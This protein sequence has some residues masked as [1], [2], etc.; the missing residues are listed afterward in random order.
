MIYEVLSLR[1]A[2]ILCIL[3]LTDVERVDSPQR[4]YTNRVRLRVNLLFLLVI[5]IE[6]VHNE[7]RCD[8]RKMCSG[9]DCSA[10]LRKWGGMWPEV[11]VKGQ[12]THC[13][14]ASL[15]QVNFYYNRIKAHLLTA[16]VIQDHKR[17]PSSAQWTLKG[18]F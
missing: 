7:Q 14:T 15:S 9:P 1:N 13:P 12:A 16:S 8:G 11:R 4:L 2:S 17:Q 10:W 6:F 5:K 3:L 18:W